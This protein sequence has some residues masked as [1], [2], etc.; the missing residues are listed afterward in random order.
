MM[1]RS[2]IDALEPA[3]GHKCFCRADIGEEFE[4]LPQ[5]H[6]DGLEPAADRGC[7]RPFQGETG[8]LDAVERFLR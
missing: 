2:T 4:F 6:I 1:T 5:P 3:A 7:Q 8:A